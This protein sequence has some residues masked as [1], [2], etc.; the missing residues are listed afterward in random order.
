MI[1]MTRVKMTGR[2]RGPFRYK[3]GL[4]GRSRFRLGDE[5]IDLAK[6]RWIISSFDGA[7][8]QVA[9][10]ASVA[11][12][13]PVQAASSGLNDR[14]WDWND[15]ANGVDEIDYK[16]KANYVIAEGGSMSA[17]QS[18]VEGHLDLIARANWITQ[19]SS[20]I[21]SQIGP[22][23]R[24]G[25]PLPVPWGTII[26]PTGGGMPTPG[27]GGTI[28]QVKETPSAALWVAGGIGLVAL[29]AA[30]S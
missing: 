24:D 20:Q 11:A 30:L 14:I 6:A 9:R 15:L 22:Q 5:T 4:G 7:A 10:G 1:G 18:E 23:P 16:G 17:N 13:N 25:G 19:V 29:I 12:N 8:A 28:I 26:Q 2:G 27:P 21:A 3:S